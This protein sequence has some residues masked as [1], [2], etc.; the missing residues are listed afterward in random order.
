MPPAR[1][2]APG[3]KSGPQKPC[4]SAVTK[5]DFRP[6]LSVTGEH[7]A[8]SPAAGHA[9]GLPGSGAAAALASRARVPFGASLLCQQGTRATALMA[10]QRGAARRLLAQQGDSGQA[11]SQ[12]YPYNSNR[13]KKHKKGDAYLGLKNVVA[14]GL[15]GKFPQS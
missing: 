4:A 3:V 9:E 14:T 12:I 8:S 11:C 5:A 2:P 15:L 6:S 1:I 13:K 7:G 10:V